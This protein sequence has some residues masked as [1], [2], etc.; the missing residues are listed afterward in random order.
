MILRGYVSDLRQ[1]F[2]F[3]W[4]SEGSYSFTRPGIMEEYLNLLTMVDLLQCGISGEMS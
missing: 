1:K 4:G 2:L 3:E